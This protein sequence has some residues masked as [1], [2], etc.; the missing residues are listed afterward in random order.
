MTSASMSRGSRAARGSDEWVERV[1]AATD[2]VE[3]IGQTVPLKRVGRNWVG[4]CPFHKEKTP[5]FSVNPDRQFYHCFSCKVGGDVFKFV[6]ETERLGFVEAVE[7]LSRR[8]GIAIPERREAGPGREAKLK[9]NDALEAAAQA[10]E[11]W[12]ADPTGGAEVR[13]YLER[14]GIERETSRRFRLGFAPAGWDHLQRRLGSRVDA[15][16]LVAAGLAVA[17]EGKSGQYDR[18]RNR[19][20]VPLVAPGGAVVGFGARALAAEDSPKYLNS[21][22]TAV[23]HKSTFLFALDQA[24]KA[25]EADGELILV[26]GYFDAIAFHQAGLANTVATSGTAL[27]PDHARVLRRL[28]PRVALTYDGDSAGRDAMMRSLSVL[29]AEG[30][31]VAVVDL[32]AGEDPDTLV[33]SGGLAAWNAAR[34]A[35]ADPV[36]FVQRHVLRSGGAGD[37]RE[38]ALR[39]IVALLGKVQDPVK[40]DLVAERA[41]RVLGVSAA[42]LKRAIGLERR[43]FSAEQPVAAVVRRERG[44]ESYEERELLRAL[45]LAPQCL[46]HAAATLAPGDFRDAECARLAAWLWSGAS[47]LPDE[48]GPAALARELSAEAAPELDWE[49]EAHGAVRRLQAR[50]MRDHQR[51]LEQELR[52]ATDPLEVERLMKSIHELARSLKDLRVTV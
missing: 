6:Q 39:A 8:A 17:R 28:V 40:L 41:E 13:A 22:E 25:V 37:P 42:V 1:R 4:L 18:F 11:H 2:I 26:E 47:G 16:T 10:Y 12:L 5:S 45:L 14:R 9:L 38:R 33:R 34:A 46:E 30:L 24:R 20:M 35:A 52:R 43:G 21:P 50:R 19:L 36:E 15:A 49:A 29:L 32:P 44:R 48:E 7:L 51:E 3:F 31:D 23:Y 27:T